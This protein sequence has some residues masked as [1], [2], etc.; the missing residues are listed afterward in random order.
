MTTMKIK[1]I[2]NPHAGKGI[3]G[4][5]WPQ[6]HK[7]LLRVLGKF[8]LDMTTGIGDATQ[9][10]RDSLSE[11]FDWIIA[12]GGDGT[13][14][15]VVNGFFE[16]ETLINSEAVFS[17]LTSG[18][19]GDFRRTFGISRDQ[20]EAIDKMANAD[21]RKVDVGRL[22]FVAHDGGRASRHFINIA[23]F[24]MSGE[25][26]MRINR[27]SV[28]NFLGGSATFLWAS[29][30]TLISYKNKEVKIVVDDQ[31]DQPLK[32]RLVIVANGQY[33]GGGMWFAP[34][35]RIDDG[36]FDIVIMGDIS[37]LRSITNM[38]K[39]YKGTHI[40][41]NEIIS[42]Q[43]KKLTATSDETVY[44]DVDGEAPGRLPADF[45]ILPGILNLKC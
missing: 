12:H 4:K 23:S 28:P 43:G 45:E 19:G 37:R 31:F 26:D 14:N 11:G 30:Q 22:N 18:I 8:D 7:K 16:G 41:E 3:T 34:G 44:L 38:S 33:A 9:I 27:T 24:G 36:I 35:A 40:G 2:V 32:V 10:T 15:E 25:V 21:V 39:I 42:L 1:V 17:F 29:F 6:T 5:R 13:I 20:D